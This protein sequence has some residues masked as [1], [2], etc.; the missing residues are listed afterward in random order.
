VPR[1]VRPD[2]EQRGTREK[3]PIL[4]PDGIPRCRA[5]DGTADYALPEQQDLEGPLL[6]YDCGAFA[7]YFT[8]EWVDNGVGNERYCTGGGCESCGQAGTPLPAWVQRHAPWQGGT[9]P[10]S[11]AAMEERYDL[12]VPETL[13]EETAVGAG[14]WVSHRKLVRRIYNAAR[15]V[16]D[17]LKGLECL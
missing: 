12:L 13:Y 2:A 17:A 16:M 1:L 4:G 5:K 3:H 9:Y 7:A 6:C 15:S 11:P 8:Y 10:C 14:Q